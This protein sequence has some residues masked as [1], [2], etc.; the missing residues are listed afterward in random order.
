MNTATKQSIQNN[1]LKNSGNSVVCRKCKSTQ[2]VANKRGYSFGLMFK[3]LFS[4][5]GIGLV[6][7][8]IGGLIGSALDSFI[9]RYYASIPLFISIFLGLP[10]SILCGFKGRNSIVNGCMNCG[11]KWL[12]GK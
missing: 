7:K 2:V 6:I 4:L 9:M 8:I 5:I 12:A 11:N 3:V 1:S 10:I